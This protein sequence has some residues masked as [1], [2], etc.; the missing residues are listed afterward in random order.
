MYELGSFSTFIFSHPTP[1]FAFVEFVLAW[2]S[3]RPSPAFIPL[4]LLIATLRVHGQLIANRDTRIRGLLCS[5]VSVTIGSTLARV[6]SASQALSS[7]GQSFGAVA[8]LSGFTYI[9]AILAFYLDLRIQA[10]WRLKS[11]WAKLTLFPALWAVIWTAASRISPVGRLLTW[12]PAFGTHAY[13]WVIPYAG[14]AGIDWILAAWATIFAEIAGIL[15]MGPGKIEVEHDH[16]RSTVSLLELN[17]R[18]AKPQKSLKSRSLISL[19]SIVVLLALPS[20]VT[21]TMHRRSD[22]PDSTPLTVG[23]VLPSSHKIVRPT[24]DDYIRE[25]ATMTAAKLLLFPESAVVFNSPQEREAAFSKIREKVRGPLLGVAFDEYVQDP[26]HPSDTRFKRNGLAII[27][28]HQKEGQ[29][30]IQYYKRNLVPFTE[31][32]NGIPSVDPPMIYNFNLSN[33]SGYTKP[34]WAPPPDFTRP[35]PF[36]SSICLDLAFPNAFAGLESRPAMILAPARTWDTTVGL[37]MWE[38][39]KTRAEEIG[40]MVLWCD[41]GSNGVS[42]VGGAGISEIMQ[43]G[44]GSWMRTVGIEWPF[45]DRRTVYARAGQFEVSIFLVLVMGGSWVGLAFWLRLNEG[46]RTA[47]TGMQTALQSVPFVRRVLWRRQSEAD[48]IDVEGADERQ[49]LLN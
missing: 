35:I 40:S 5:W 14:P 24:L 7:P 45:D 6:S 3:L 2:V 15:L 22:T 21:E 42:G 46:T 1:V 47:V 23:C 39:A 17:E 36:T 48:L 26:A 25:A 31:S 32:F 41:G 10:V 20:F 4:L 27:H 13:T 37:A 8:V 43:V 44:G 16:N 38:Q 11:H 33:P 18:H 34:E 49:N 28:Q 30:V 29:E 19:T 12:S 9:C